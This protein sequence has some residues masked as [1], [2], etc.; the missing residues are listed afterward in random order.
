MAQLSGHTIL[1]VEDESLIALD[2]M[3]VLHSE[4]AQVIAARSALEAFDGAAHTKIS[5]AI[6][7][8]NLGQ[9]GDCGPICRMLQERHVPFIFHTGYRVGGVLEEFPR[10]SI[11]MKPATKKQLLDCVIGA[12]SHTDARRRYC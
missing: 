5:A 3:A 11:L 7:D 4:D 12:L 8:I 1:I 6:L 2:M 10:A 9:H